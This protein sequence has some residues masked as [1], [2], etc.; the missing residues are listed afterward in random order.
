GGFLASS[1]TDHTPYSQLTRLSFSLHADLARTL[2]GETRYGYRP[3]R[4][5]SVQAGR[6][7]KGGGE[8][9]EEW[10]DG[11]DVGRWEEIGTPDNCAQVHPFCFT[12]TLLD[13]AVATG[14]VTVM[15]GYEAK[16]LRYA[17]GEVIAG[18]PEPGDN[19]DKQQNSGA[20]WLGW[21]TGNGTASS[22]KEDSEDP[23]KSPTAGS[24]P[25]TTRNHTASKPPP[26]VTGVLVSASGDVPAT[27]SSAETLTEPSDGDGVESTTCPHTL[28]PS[29]QA[30]AHPHVRIPT[31]TYH[32]PASST[33]PDTVQP[34]QA[35]IVDADVVVVATGPWV[36]EAKEWVREGVKWPKV[37]YGHRAHSIV[38]RP[39]DPVTATALFLTYRPQNPS[40]PT[41]DPE[42]YPRPDGNVYICGASD[43]ASLPRSA[44]LFVPV[45]ESCDTLK[46]VGA[47]ISSVLKDAVEHKR[48]CCWIPQVGDRPLV[49]GILNAP[50]TG[51]V[52]S[53]L[54]VD[55]EVKCVDASGFMEA[56]GKMW[57]KGW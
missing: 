23:S 41:T 57:S 35:R 43:V 28:H 50:A 51:K 44:S 46:D 4:V 17:G 54:L 1:W 11:E 20:G 9:V 32:L 22:V 7:A 48:Q 53:E 34:D 25:R 3:V 5:A 47:R 10:V 39:K 2:Q 36:A 19:G 40:L 8:R 52:L 14:R 6:G 12:H 21:L 55:G 49:W 16:G 45:P 56:G 13:A 31:P 15:M 42:V 26:R 24:P 33:H 37:G 27:T 29:A 18:T 30:H 38:L